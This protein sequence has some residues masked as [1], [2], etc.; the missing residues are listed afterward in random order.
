MDLS[1]A[2][3]DATN[4]IAD[5]IT[6]E[7]CARANN[8]AAVRNANYK[9]DRSLRAAAM[10]T[11]CGVE[12]TTMAGYLPTKGVKNLEALREA[13]ADACPTY[14]PSVPDEKENVATT[15]S[16][17]YGDV[18]SIMPLLQFGTCGYTGALHHPGLEVTDENVAYILTAKIF[19]LTAYNLL[20]NK[21]ACAKALM[22]NYT[23]EL[24]KESYIEYM[25]S[26]HSTEKIDITPVPEF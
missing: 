25:E 19:A 11:G 16:T 18:S 10:A 21:G 13:I 23:A 26:M 20:K 4:I 15:G 1:P 24:T 8:I 12:I 22:E 17:D 2:A 9:V 14:D 5:N 6:M 3:G 7:Y